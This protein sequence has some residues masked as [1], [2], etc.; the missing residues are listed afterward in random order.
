MMG[1]DGNMFF[2]G[3]FM[4][5]IWVLIIVALVIVLKTTMGNGSSGSTSKGDSPLE[6]LQKRYARGEIDEEE[7]KR[8]R[9]QLEG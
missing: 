3:G 6:I 4:W 9:K 1:S 7:F 8:K 2:G 5:I